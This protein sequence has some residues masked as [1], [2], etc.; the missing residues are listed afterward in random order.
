MSGEKEVRLREGE[1]HRLMSAARQVDD[2]QDYLS[3]LD[4]QLSQ[5]RK[6]IQR[7]QREAEKRQRALQNSINALSD[8]LQ[9][10]ARE[11]NARLEDQRQ[12][13]MKGMAELD[14]QIEAQ[15]DEFV[16]SV[17]RLDQRI[18]AQGQAFAARADALD[19]QMAQQRRELAQS[20]DRLDQR[21]E[22]QGRAF[23]AR[24]DALDQRMAHQRQEYLD[25]IAEQAEHV[26]QQFAR[27]AQQES[28]AQARADQWLRDADVLLNH[29]S[30]HQRHQQFAPGELDV[31][32]NELALSQ[33]NIRQG[34]FQAAIATG[35]AL[36]S[37]ALK[38]QAEIEF[39]QLEWDTYHAEALRGARTCMAAVEAQVMAKWVFD[40]DEEQ[41]ELDAE[42]DY[43]SDG[44]LTRLKDRVAAGL[45]TLEQQTPTLDELKRQIASNQT[46]QA[47]LDDVVTLAK[48]RLIASQLRVNIAEDVLGDLE[49]SGWQ[50]LDSVWQG[51][52]ADDGKGWKNS[53]HMKLQ[54]LGGN[55]M[56]SI[57]L[58]EETP[59]GQIENRVQFAYFPKNNNDARFAAAQTERLSN[60]LAKLGLTQE[61]LQ[62][63][64]GHEQTIRGDEVRRDFDKIR[65][66]AP[67][68][69]R[70]QG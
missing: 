52:E 38:L 7:N 5:A 33:A 67:A 10:S 56:I 21:I 3:E 65:A 37:K 34:H 8:E 25:L 12:D 68:P 50:L 62:C 30:Q 16:Q 23:A 42:I 20:V 51:E 44:A 46:L 39:R 22:A 55:E 41:R 28:D 58:P 2:N 54:D 17:G 29:I 32:R 48:E 19:Q 43:W 11:F 27:L 63:V 26:Q 14:R 1:Y 6:S 9:D 53:Y 45:T 57:I 59:R 24:A 15:R 18:E 61:R 64:P 4:H 69:R 13:F 47:E 66:T 70:I 40:T 36:Y 60:T 31:L 35:Q 49:Q